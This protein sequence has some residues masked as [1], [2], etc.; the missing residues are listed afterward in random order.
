[1]KSIF[2]TARVGLKTLPH[3]EFGIGA[4]FGL[5]ILMDIDRERNPYLEYWNIGILETRWFVRH[6][7]LRFSINTLLQYPVSCWM[8]KTQGGPHELKRTGRV[9]V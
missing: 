4:A 5:P 7:P 2:R 3:S 6:N 9:A 8:T 1:M